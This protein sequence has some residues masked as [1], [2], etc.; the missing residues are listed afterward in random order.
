MEYRNNMEYRKLNTIDQVIRK[1]HCALSCRTEYCLE[2]R[3]FAGVADISRPLICRLFVK[4]LEI[5][6]VLV[7]I[8]RPHTFTCSFAFP[9]YLPFSLAL[10]ERKVAQNSKALSFPK[11]EDSVRPTAPRTKTQRHFFEIKK[12]KTQLSDF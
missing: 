6:V 9:P 10:F 4:Y 12:D 7:Q 2:C 11:F 1:A 3:Q 8:S 5:F